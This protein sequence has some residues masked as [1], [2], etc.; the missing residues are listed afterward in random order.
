MTASPDLVV[1]FVARG[2]TDDEWRMV[3]VEQGPWHPPFVNE[4]RRLQDRLYE[5]VEAAP[6]GQLAVKFPDSHGKRV[7]VQL[8]G[9]RPGDRGSCVLPSI[10]S[11]RARYR[12][13]SRRAG[14]LPVRVCDIFRVES[15]LTAALGSRETKKE[16]GL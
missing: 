9:Y 8:D 12:R 5:C 13:I 4:L 1:D 10:C 6:G 7:D 15:E 16:K 3:L 14:V 2:N 11:S